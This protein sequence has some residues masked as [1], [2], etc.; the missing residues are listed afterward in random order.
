MTRQIGPFPVY[1]YAIGL[2]ALV[3]G[4]WYFKTH[5]ASNAA[6]APQTNY[7]TD[8]AGGPP[9]PYPD[10]GSGAAGIPPS[11]AFD[12]SGATSVPQ[13]TSQSNFNPTPAGTTSSQDFSNAVNATTPDQGRFRATTPIP[14]PQQQSQIQQL[15]AATYNIPIIGGIIG[16][17]AGSPSSGY[18]PTKTVRGAFA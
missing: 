8:A 14:T 12:T 10:P 17:I 4:V 3:G 6:V 7:P 11:S 15:A 1:A 13:Y 18:V 9:L 2:I 5:N 16:G